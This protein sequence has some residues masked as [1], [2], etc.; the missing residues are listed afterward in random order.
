MN[1]SKA[2]LLV[3]CI[4]FVISADEKCGSTGVSCQPGFTCCRCPIDPQICSRGW[5]CFAIPNAICCSDGKTACPQGTKCE[6]Q[7][8]ETKCV[9]QVNAFLS[10]F[11]DEEIDF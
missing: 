3:I 9:R 11:A 7:G 8:S 6:K 1:I 4:S 5:R 10:N 2:I